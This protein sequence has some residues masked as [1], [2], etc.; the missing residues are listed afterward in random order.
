MTIFLLLI[1][2]IIFVSLGLPDSIIG[3]VWPSMANSFGVS[4]DYQGIVTITISICTIISS[5]FTVKLLNWFKP[6]YVVI[7]SILLTCI[8][9]V[10]MSYSIEFYLLILSCIPFGLGAG[11]IDCTLNNYVAINY[12]AIHMNFLHAFWGV[13]TI[14]SPLILGAFLSNNSEGWRIGVLVLAAIQ[15]VIFVFCV[16]TIWVW[17]KASSEFDKRE[18]IEEK[19]EVVKLGFFKTF[20]IRG[21]LFAII[22]FFSYIAV[23]SLTGMWISSFATYGVSDVVEFSATTVAQFTSLFYLGITVGRFLGGL[24]SLKLNDEIRLRIGEGII[25]LGVIFL[26]TTTFIKSAD[27]ISIFIPVSAFLIGLGCGP[28]Y[29]AII[30]A[31]PERFTKSLSQNVMSVQVGCAYI[32]NIS[33]AP[34]FGVIGENVSFLLLPLIIFIFLFLLI[35]GNE[36]V[37]F[38]VKDKTKLIDLSKK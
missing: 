26:S 14:I 16:S 20:K 37:L 18:K 4:A 2:Y 17:K 24:L 12:K 9:I 30:H 15:T 1:I 5:F 35:G 6:Q 21:V 23:E 27:Y 25:L 7:S 34:L 28:V 22:A 36:M 11:A 19:N 33:V 29:P 10:C 32:A 31:T 8:G 13:G 3:S 38:K